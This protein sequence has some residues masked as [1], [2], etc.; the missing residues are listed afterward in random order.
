MPGH[1]YKQRTLRLADLTSETRWPDF[2]ARAAELGVGSMLAIQLYVDG[3]DLG[4]LNLFS[5]ETDAFCDESEHVGL[6]FASH[7]AV[8][9]AGRRPKT[10]C[11]RQWP[12]GT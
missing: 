2:T 4:A 3:E 8:V 6:L 10:S 9:M 7:A 11:V 12:P 5:A 1:P